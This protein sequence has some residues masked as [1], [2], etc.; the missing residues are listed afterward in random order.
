MDQTDETFVPRKKLA[1]TGQ[2]IIEFFRK[3][4]T[5]TAIAVGILGLTAV[6]LGPVRLLLVESG[7][8]TGEESVLPIG[9]G[10]QVAG[11]DS[12][13]W[14][15]DAVV[16]RKPVAYT[17]IPDRT[18][19]RVSTYTVQAGDT[20]FAI[21]ENFGVEPNTLLWANSD[22]L[23]NNVHMLQPGIDLFI[24]PVDGVYHTADGV[25]TIQWI[26]DNYGVDPETIL[27][28]EYNDL[29]DYT[30]ADIP[31][32]GM[33]IVIPGGISD[34]VDWTPPVQE[35]V[36]S[37]TGAVSYAF[38]PGMGGSCASG[39]V[40]SGGSGVWAP[41][42]SPGSYA[43]TQGY[44]F[45]H[46]GID[47][48][49]PVGTPVIAADSGVVVFSGWVDASWGYGILVVLDHG[50]GWTS[51]Y[52]HL[53]S[54]GAGCGQVVSRGEYVGAVGSTGNSSGPHLHFEMR[55]GHEPDNPAAYVGF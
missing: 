14:Q 41:P 36:D 48:A 45:G 53:S 54:A 5:A 28:S 7:D 47:L 10:L 33:R 16:E 25:R 9:T 40:G 1:L 51:Y 49:A 38:M 4:F 31:P 29:E 39:I 27:N 18:R 35:V 37:S 34:A 20:L 44:Y 52:A 15:S 32:W 2:Q 50:N 6:V 19:N 43:F 46:S 12:D 55:W 21:A 30:A 13:G 24:M 23:H 22:S 17:T 8:L 3:N 42:I 11:G 26:A